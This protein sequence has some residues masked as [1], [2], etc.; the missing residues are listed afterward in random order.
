[1]YLPLS[2]PQFYSGG[3]KELAIFS[4]DCAGFSSIM[5]AINFV[6]IILNM[7]IPEI[8]MDKMHLFEC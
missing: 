4:L 7:G 3:S 1:M 6:A 8:A 2:G 5:G